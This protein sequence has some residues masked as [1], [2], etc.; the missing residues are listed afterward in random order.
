MI[1]TYI[2]NKTLDLPCLFNSSNEH[3]SHV[4]Y[5]ITGLLGTEEK[6]ADM[7]ASEEAKQCSVAMSDVDESGAIGGGDGDGGWSWEWRW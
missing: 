7:Q 4:H 5:E 1:Y 6:K 2:I 3:R